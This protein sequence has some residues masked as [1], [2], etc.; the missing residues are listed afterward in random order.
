MKIYRVYLASHASFVVDV[1]ARDFDEA[2]S[3]A[4]NDPGIPVGIDSAD[5]SGWDV[6]SITEIEG[7]Q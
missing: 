1:I 6:H 3:I 4:L 5:L 7:E 2:A